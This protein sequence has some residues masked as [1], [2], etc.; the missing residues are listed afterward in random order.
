MDKVTEYLSQT[1]PCL[2]LGDDVIVREKMVISL[3]GKYKKQIGSRAADGKINIPT[4]DRRW[5]AK[6]MPTLAG[7]RLSR[8]QRD[9]FLLVLI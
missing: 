8:G 3:W 5:F 1:E 9:V 2:I 4:D 7:G 6:L